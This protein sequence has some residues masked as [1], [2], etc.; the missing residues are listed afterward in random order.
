[1]HASLFKGTARVP[2]VARFAQAMKVHAWMSF[3]VNKGMRETLRKFSDCVCV[4]VSNNP[5]TSAGRFE[6]N[7]ESKNDRVLAARGKE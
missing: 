7:A 6:T 3:I 4:T 1:M 5:R 2:Q